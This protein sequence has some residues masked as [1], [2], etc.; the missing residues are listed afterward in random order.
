MT[1]YVDLDGVLADYDTAANEA[2]GTDNHYKFEFIWGADVYWKRLH[3]RGDFFSSL[4][5]MPGAKGL[6]T[7]LKPY[8]TKILTALP[9]TGAESV[10]RQKR[11]WVNARIDYKADVITCKTTEKPDYCK[12]GD[13]L[14]DD[15]A[16]N[17]D[18]WI[19]KGGT[20]IIHTT[21]ERTIGTL[22]ALGIING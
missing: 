3:A 18:A 13:I 9:K 19:A 11:K 21:A 6:W 4:P 7:T 10:D 22:K 5:L 8:G 14:I 20:Y 2:L 16:I 17:R 15:R 12:P 1:I